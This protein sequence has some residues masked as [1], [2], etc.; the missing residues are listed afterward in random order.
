MLAKL[1]KKEWGGELLYLGNTANSAGQVVMFRKC[2][3]CNTELGNLSKDCVVK[4][5]LG[6]KQFAIV[7]SYA[8]NTTKVKVVL[9]CCCFF[10]QA[11]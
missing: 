4:V 11:S 3:A 9:F 2:L 5:D 1:G 6:G 8:P 7:N 10:G